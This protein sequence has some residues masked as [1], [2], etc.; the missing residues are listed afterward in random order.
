MRLPQQIRGA[1][2]IKKL[3]ARQFPGMDASAAARLISL[4]PWQQA[5]IAYE[6]PC[7]ECGGLPEG[8]VR[9]PD[10]IEVQFRCPKGKCKET[11]NFSLRADLNRNILDRG[12]SRFGGDPSTLVGAA[13]RKFS[14]AVKEGVIP[15]GPLFPVLIRLT[16][17]QYYLFMSATIRQFSAVVHECLL[18]L[19]EE[20]SA[21]N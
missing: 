18:R 2:A 8:P 15:P 3:L 5:Q 20:P 7:A 16:R 1:A 21:R 13:L 4:T 11:V 9:T 6:V 10:G 12:L 17:T 19:V 14:Q